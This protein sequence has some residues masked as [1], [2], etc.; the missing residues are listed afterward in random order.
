MRGGN[1]GEDEDGEG[2]GGGGWVGGWVGGV[3]WV[4][5]ARRRHTHGMGRRMVGSNTAPKKRVQVK[6]RENAT[7]ARAC[8]A[9]SS[10]TAFPFDPLPEGPRRPESAHATVARAGCKQGLPW[11]LPQGLTHREGVAARGEDIPAP[12]GHLCEPT[13]QG[14]HRVALHSQGLHNHGRAIHTCVCV[15][16]WKVW[17][18]LQRVEL[19]QGELQQKEGD[20][21]QGNGVRELRR[22]GVVKGGTVATCADFT[23]SLRHLA[24]PSTC[25]S[26]D[27]D[28]LKLSKNTAEPKMWPP[29]RPPPAAAPTPPLVPP[30]V[31]TA[32]SNRGDVKDAGST[33]C[34][35][36]AHA[37]TR[38]GRGHP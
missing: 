18:Q 4:T 6:P 19:V 36:R 28:E 23:A 15:R 26:N 31:C 32:D 12:D 38:R 8:G 11:C 17:K 34:L 22:G 1:G 24:R 25:A 21:A 35:Q 9:E 29:A 13:R 30:A 33:R 27:A 5:W 16:A 14:V 2:G 7:G 37:R 10:L 20:A 3:K